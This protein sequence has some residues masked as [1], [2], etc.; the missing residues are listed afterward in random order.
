MKTIFNVTALCLFSFAL[1]A[2]VIFVNKNVNGGN[3][4]GTSWDNA[5][6]D[7]RVAI[8]NTNYGD[9]IWV[10]KGNLLSHNLN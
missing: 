7:L 3:N 9:T 1:S 4:D 8:Q 5:F 2:Q 10:A 6:T